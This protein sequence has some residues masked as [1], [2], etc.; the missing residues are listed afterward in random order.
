MSISFFDRKFTDQNYTAR[1]HTPRNSSDL[2]TALLLTHNRPAR[3]MKA[4]KNLEKAKNIKEILVVWDNPKEDDLKLLDKEWKVPVKIIIKTTD[5]LTNR[6]EAYNHVTTEGVYIQDDDV[7]VNLTSLEFAHDV[8]IENKE[9]LVGLSPKSHS[10]DTKTK[11][12][13]YSYNP[14]CKFSMAV[15]PAAVFHK[16]WLKRYFS[17]IPANI[18]SKV[19]KIMNCEDI[20]LNFLIANHT[21]L[22][23]III[24]PFLK[25]SETRC[26][27]KDCA[28]N[29]LSGRKTH[30]K[31]RD[32][33][34][35]HFVKVY[36]RMPLVYANYFYEYH[37]N[38]LFKQTKC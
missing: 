24:K 32:D 10:Y 18:I 21:G 19:D 29:R 25:P 38:V 31:Q 20:A 35:N 2:L 16:I 6:F 27:D 36:S 22:P 13:K 33:C 37:S 3:L 26:T 1:R 14:K 28:G 23:P 15:T 12:Y 11:K 5:K 8:W 7:I 30:G 34:L 4:L 9:R 17:D